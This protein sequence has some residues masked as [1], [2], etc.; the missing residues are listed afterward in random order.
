VRTVV[1][2]PGHGGLDP[3]AIGVGGLREKEV[4]LR[5]AQALG[6]RLEAQGFRVVHTRDGDRT[7]S[8]EERTAIAESVDGDVF[9][10]IHANAAPRRSVHGIETYYLDEN[11]ERHALNLAAR[12]N[13]IPH[14]EVN[15][16]Q[17]TLAKLHI[18]E[19]SPRSQRLAALL[20]DQ[21]VS[22][23][24]HGSRPNDLGVKKGPF[25]VLFL[26]NMPA[27]LIEVGFL[28]NQDEARR[29]RD[30]RYLEQIAQEIARGVER[31]RGEQETLLA[32]AERP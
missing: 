26:S 13:G 3:G 17:R 29:L 1:V 7:L 28:T 2:D 8:L 24:P 23:L 32:R 30:D 6:Q 27:A 22:G 15:V 14:R 21:V 16:L 19:V 11:H 20:Q 12:E 31:Y 18:E 5:V 4:T 10:S 9:V 25:Y